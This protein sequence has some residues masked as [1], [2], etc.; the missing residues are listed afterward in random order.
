MNTLEVLLLIVIL[1]LLPA[2]IYLAWVRRTERYNEEAWT[3]LLKAFFYG[4]IIGTSV[5]LILELIL[6]NV[7][8]TI[9]QPDFGSVPQ[10]STATTLILACLIAPFVEEGM[11]ALGV[12]GSRSQFRFVADGLVFGAA[13]GLGFGFME[14]VLYGSSAFFEAG[15]ASAVAT[16]IVRS[17]SSI[18]L[19]GSA[20]AMSGYGV[21]ENSLHEGRGHILL[22]YFMLAVLMHA[23]FNALAYLPLILPSS[24]MSSLGTE[25][26]D[27]LSLLLLVVAV[28]YALSAFSHIRKR[29]AEL[30]FQPMS[31][32]KIL[33]VPK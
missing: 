15:L 16:L 8:S 21:A 28:A 27:I 33:N 1:S 31:A 14:N 18:L 30:Q 23:S 10:G 20:T 3:P 2:L 11:K 26:S 5:S 17:V 29:I 13:V 4:A 22:G 9:L 6:F 19:H 7:Y 12:Y 32:G 25:G 24:W